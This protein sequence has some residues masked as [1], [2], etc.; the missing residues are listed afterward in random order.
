LGPGW[1]RAA[2]RLLGDRGLL[3]DAE[4][5]AV[6]SR[7][8]PHEWLD[9]PAG[10]LKTDA[11][12]HADDHFFPRDQDPAWDVAGLGAEFAL[13]REREDELANLVAQ[14]ARDPR[15]PLRTGFYA[16]AY[17]AFHLGYAELARVT[18]GQG[19]RE[20]GR[21]RRRAERLRHELRLL[22]QLQ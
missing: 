6:D 13:G 20:T 8:M 22:L 11:V 4:T 12:D 3:E 15:L 9:T 14:T 21:F 17:R 16:V 5:I 10:L 1:G 18:L 7:M 2:D 19:D